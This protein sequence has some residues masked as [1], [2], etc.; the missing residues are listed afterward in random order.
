LR[1]ICDARVIPCGDPENAPGRPA[2]RPM[3]RAIK[4]ADAKH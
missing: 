4:N 1:S 2:N 3:H